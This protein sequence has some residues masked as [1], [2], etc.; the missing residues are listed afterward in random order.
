MTSQ[1]PRQTQQQ[2]T[3]RQNFV[4]RDHKGRSRYQMIT[5][6][7][8]PYSMRNEIPLPYYLQQHEV[9]KNQLT[10]CTQIPNTAESFQM[11]FVLYLMA[12][13][14]ITSSKLLM[15]FTGTVPEFSVE[16]FL[17][18]VTA[19]LLINL[20]TKFVIT[21]LHQNWIHKRTALVQTTLNGA[22]QKWFSAFSIEIKSNWKRITQDCSKMFDSKGN[23]QNLRLLCKTI[24]RLPNKRIKELG[25]RI[26]I[27]I[28]KTYSLNTHDYKKRKKTEKMTLTPQLR[29]TAITIRASHPSSNREQVKSSANS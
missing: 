16:S 22:A 17:N 3:T 14:S 6:G 2:Y 8:Q 18:T 24:R 7:Y 12:G 11:T 4:Q 23:K 9:F 28:Q 5:Q 26:E 13:S 25:S 19:N 27:L 21:P 1:R 10:D 20:G 29:T 15:V